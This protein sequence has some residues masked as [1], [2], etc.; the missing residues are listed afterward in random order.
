LSNE[1]VETGMIWHS[2]LAFVCLIGGLVSSV[3][4]GWPPLRAAAI[5]FAGGLAAVTL[6]NLIDPNP[7]PCL[8]EAKGISLLRAYSLECAQQ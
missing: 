6:I 4:F 8:Q 2:W 1:R 5:G 3:V 7:A